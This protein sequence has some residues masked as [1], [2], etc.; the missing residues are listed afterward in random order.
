MGPRTTAAFGRLWSEIAAELKLDPDNQIA[1]AVA[2]RETWSG[3]IS[4]PVDDGGER[5]PADFG[6][7]CI[8]SGSQFSRLSGFGVC[9]DLDRINHLARARRERPIGL[10]LPA[11]A[12]NNE[13]TAI[14]AEPESHAATESAT[15]ES[16]TTESAT[17][18]SATTESAAPALPIA[19]EALEAETDGAETAARPDRPSISV[20]PAAANVVPFRTGTSPETKVPALSPVERRA[21]RELAQ[22]LTARLQGVREDLAEQSGSDALPAEV[23][24]PQRNPRC[25][26]PA[27]TAEP[28]WLARMVR[29][30]KRRARRYRNQ[31]R[32]SNRLC[33]TAFHSA[34]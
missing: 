30:T 3:I 2:T 9:R 21:F 31:S 19:A 33:S 7:S 14:P 34:C 28:L 23:R 17:T 26:A 29:R 15:T 12:P 8:R 18:E 1:R 22:E 13:V 27:P 5:L 10:M 32:H 24:Y 6:S 4:W 11:D 25:R 16:A 20:V